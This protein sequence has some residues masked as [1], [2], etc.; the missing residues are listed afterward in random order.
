MLPRP[1]ART[2]P[3]DRNVVGYVLIGNEAHRLLLEVSLAVALPVTA[4]PVKY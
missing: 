3:A 1:Y 4:R 2:A